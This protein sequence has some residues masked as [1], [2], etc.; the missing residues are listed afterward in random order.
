VCAAPVQGFAGPSRLILS[1]PVPAWQGFAGP[2]RLIP[3]AL[4]VATGK[5]SAPPRI[6]QSG[7]VSPNQGPARRQ[8]RGRLEEH[9]D[10]LNIWG[11]A[12]GLS[13]YI[14]RLNVP[15]ATLMKR[16]REISIRV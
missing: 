6:A 3:D 7:P 15:P 5:V 14:H 1:F 12:G 9:L 4:R 8:M 2:A 13:W 10:H 16:T 11:E